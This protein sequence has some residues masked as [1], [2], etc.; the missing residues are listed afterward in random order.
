[1]QL[2]YRALLSSQCEA[3]LLEVNPFMPK[4]L[5]RTVIDVS[6]ACI[7]R[8]SRL[9]H[10]NRCIVA[11]S[12]L[13]DQLNDVLAMSVDQLATRK[14]SLR[15]NVEQCCASLA[16][17]LQTRRHFM[18]SE[19]SGRLA[20]DPRYL[21]FEFVWNIILRQKQ[22]SI[23]DNFVSTLKEG[24]SKVKQMIMGQGKTTVVAPILALMLADG[25]SLVLS[26]VPPALLEMSRTLMR[27]T[28]A[29]I[30]AKRIYTL[31]FDR[32]TEIRPSMFRALQNS[33]V[34]RG[35]VVATPSAVKSVM[36]CFVERMVALKDASSSDAAGL[37]QNIGEFTKVLGLFRR[38]VL[39]LDEVDM[40]LHPLRSELNFPIGDKYVLLALCCNSVTRGLGVCV[41]FVSIAGT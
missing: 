32:S 20:Y 24:R 36:L 3:D 22:V 4:E 26:V 31:K 7:L 41:N 16:G 34:N 5:L 11:A 13:L 35:V 1:M 12:K 8:A 21:V 17:L 38:G 28:F 23:I 14:S 29:N 6:V 33:A 27:E 2:I 19:S 40:I 9:G 25:D 37:R 39:L 10:T 30:M 18:R 15:P